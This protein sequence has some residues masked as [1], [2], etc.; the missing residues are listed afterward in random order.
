M[1]V[2][3]LITMFP[4]EN[5]AENMAF[6][7]ALGDLAK[8]KRC[9]TLMVMPHKKGCDM[10]RALGRGFPILLLRNIIRVYSVL[11]I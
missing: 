10:F 6:K 4:V 7:F 3:T 11:R 1:N 8:D 2:L 5:W 9:G